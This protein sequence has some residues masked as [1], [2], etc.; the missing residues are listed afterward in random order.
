MTDQVDSSKIIHLE[1]VFKV[2]K[3]VHWI[4]NNFPENFLKELGERRNYDTR[5][6][7]FRIN[8]IPHPNKIDTIYYHCGKNMLSEH[9]DGFENGEELKKFSDKLDCIGWELKN[10]CIV[11]YIFITGEKDSRTIMIALTDEI[12]QMHTTGK[13]NSKGADY[14]ETSNIEGVGFKK[15]F[16]GF[17]GRG[18]VRY[19]NDLCQISAFFPDK[20]INYSQK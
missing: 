15:I 2:D 11:L 10:D 16:L 8:V 18:G 5:L 6:I 20:T 19:E 4:Q 17:T 3:I 9:M 13:L 1:F 7:T 12:I 14:E